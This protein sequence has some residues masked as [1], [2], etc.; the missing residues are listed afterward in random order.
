VT[1]R[2]IIAT[3][4]LLAR[5]VGIVSAAWR[6]IGSRGSSTDGSSTDAYR[7]STAYR[8][9]TI[10]ATAIDA[11]VINASAT[12]ANASSI[13]EGIGR[14]SRNTRDASDNGCS[15]QNK[16]STRHD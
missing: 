3:K 2:P 6:V 5:W 11:T 13:C 1:E 10:N 14:N 9:T 8:C 7:H 16:G 15:K 12:N 4:A